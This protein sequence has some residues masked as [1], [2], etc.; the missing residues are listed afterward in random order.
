[1]AVIHF[2][3][4]EIEARIVYW[5]PALSGKTTSLRALHDFTPRGRRGVLETLDTQDERTLFFDYLPLMW[6]TIAGFRGR[7]KILGAPGQRIY[8]ATRRLL[9]Q[10]ADGVVFVADSSPDQLSANVES[11]NELGVALR[12]LGRDL[13]EMPLVLQYNKRDLAQALK[14]EVLQTALNPR[15]V[16]ALPS[17]ATRGEGV[18]DAFQAILELVSD[19][20][21]AEIAGGS[22]TDLVRGAVAAPLPDAEEVRQTL[23]AI[24]QLRPAE[25]RDGEGEPLPP[26]VEESEQ[27]T[28]DPLDEEAAGFEPETLEADADSDTSL[29]GQAQEPAAAV[30]G[31]SDP[32]DHSEPSEP[33]EPSPAPLDPH[34]PAYAIVTLPYLPPQ[35]Q[36]CEVHSVADPI[37]EQDGTV[38]VR[39]TLTE[40]GS[41]RPR[42]VRVRL[43]SEEAAPAPTREPYQP[44][45][46]SGHTFPT[47]F[48]LLIGFGLGVG[49]VWLFLS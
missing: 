4:R 6:G 14:V 9:L 22:G 45:P 16:P 26:P 2:S 5:G 41:G 31:S 23:H 30:P 48:T 3:R 10:G 18:A 20:V 12:S 28:A 11:F 42:R 19:R 25:E 15:A 17:V 35:L 36:G 40:P 8:R 33:S 38:M 21:E 49:V 7:V 29:P 13:G 34:A 43:V 46:Q 47:L 39:I 24:A 1:M 27:E 32:S 37:L 44:P